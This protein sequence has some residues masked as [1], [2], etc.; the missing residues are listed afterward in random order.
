MFPKYSNR[1][2]VQCFKA[3]EYLMKILR[4]LKNKEENISIDT[5]EIT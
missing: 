4:V 3:K 5:F 2:W 1:H